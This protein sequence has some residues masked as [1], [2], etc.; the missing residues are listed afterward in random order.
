MLRWAAA[1]A[2][3]RSICF[4]ED[5][6][7]AWQALPKRPCAPAPQDLP[8]ARQAFPTRWCARRSRNVPRHAFFRLRRDPTRRTRV[9][10]EFCLRQD[11]ASW[12][13]IS[14]MSGG[15]GEDLPCTLNPKRE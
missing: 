9:N 14:P 10:N 2:A 8:F 6:T 5:S 13:R 11:P 7:F 4:Q 12:K 1:K 3:A 15:W